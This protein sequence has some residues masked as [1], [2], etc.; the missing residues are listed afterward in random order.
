MTYCKIQHSTP[1]QKHRYD[2]KLPGKNRYGLLYR[3]PA[4]VISLCCCGPTGPQWS[5]CLLVLCGWVGVCGLVDGCVCMRAC[6]RAHV[7]VCVCMCMGA[8]GCVCVC[9]RAW[10][11]VCVCVCV[12][13][14][15]CVCVC[16]CVCVNRKL[17]CIL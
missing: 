4:L 13:V 5:C 6:V 8:C 15:V 1:V 2:P 11:R 3:Y 12:C 16:V 7:C 9:A 17:Y 10:V 14:R